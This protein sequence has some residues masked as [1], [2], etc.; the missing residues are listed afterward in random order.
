M[1][2]MQASVVDLWEFYAEVE[3]L[4]EELRALQQAAAAD[5]VETAIRGGSTSGEILGRLRAALSDVS[6]QVPSVAPRVSRLASWATE[7]L[8]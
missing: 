6:A 3:S 5:E 8:P 7:A 1:A 4:I 2:P